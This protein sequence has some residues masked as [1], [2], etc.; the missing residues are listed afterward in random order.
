MLELNE[1]YWNWFKTRIHTDL[2]KSYNIK[3]LVIK[4]E[5]INIL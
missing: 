2:I 3:N 4:N 1:I 5:Y